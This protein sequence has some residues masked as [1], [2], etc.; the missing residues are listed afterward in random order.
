MTIDSSTPLIPVW[1]RFVRAVH[2]LLAVGVCASLFSAWSGNGPVHLLA[3]Y[4]LLGLV[5]A[6]IVWGMIGPEHARFAEFVGHP[7]RAIRYLIDYLP[8]RTPPRYLGHNPAAGWMAAVQITLV[9]IGTLS[10][11]VVQGVFEYAGPLWYP[12][13]GLGDNAAARVYGLHLWVANGLLVLIA[14]HLIGVAASSLKHRENL[15]AAMIH[16]KKKPPSI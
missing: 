13:A 9:A 6:R 16:G 12:L 14:L 1:D 3:G 2:W 5:V 15:V 11:V 10:G 4:G 8:G 7:V